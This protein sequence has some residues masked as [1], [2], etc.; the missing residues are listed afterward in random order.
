MTLNNQKYRVKALKNTESNFETI[1]RLS[2]DG[3]TETHHILMD[4]KNIALV[5]HSIWEECEYC[6]CDCDE[7][8]II[9]LCEK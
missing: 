2:E 7:D 1:K 6:N 4:E 9:D 3:I 5:S 8:G